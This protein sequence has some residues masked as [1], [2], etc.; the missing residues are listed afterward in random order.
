MLLSWDFYIPK[1]ASKAQF[2]IDKSDNRYGVSGRSLRLIPD[3][4]VGCAKKNSVGCLND[5]AVKAWFTSTRGVY[6]KLAG[7]NLVQFLSSG[8][9]KLQ[10]KIL[11]HMISPGACSGSVMGWPSIAVPLGAA[12]SPTMLLSWDFLITKYASKAEFLLTKSA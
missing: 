8:V 9:K 5:Q 7:L 4:P 11:E 10:S 2:I 12:H 6:L 1:Y 3:W